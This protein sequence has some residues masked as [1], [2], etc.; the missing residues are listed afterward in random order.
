VQRGPDWS[1]NNEDDDH[2]HG[3]VVG[4]GGGEW[5]DEFVVGPGGGKWEKEYKGR[6]LVRWNGRMEEYEYRVG[7]DG[8]YDL[9]YAI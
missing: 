5:K 3:T 1:H 2:S 9:C 7:Q 8:K 6:C 4:P